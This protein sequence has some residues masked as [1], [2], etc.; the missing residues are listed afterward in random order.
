MINRFQSPDLSVCV[1][2]HGFKPMT[3][4]AKTS[5][6]LQ[7]LLKSVNH[8]VNSVDS[9]KILSSSL[10]GPVTGDVGKLGRGVMV[11]GLGAGF[12]EGGA[13]V[14]DFRR[15]VVRRGDERAALERRA[16]AEA[17]LAGQVARQALEREILLERIN[18]DSRPTSGCGADRDGR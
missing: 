15:L 10:L 16:A 18:R 13:G 9:V 1:N 6:L 8:S 2:F 3:R 5:S 12:A 4:L 7:G 14:A 17:F 11:G